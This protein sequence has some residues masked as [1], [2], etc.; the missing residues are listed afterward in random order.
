MKRR[1]NIQNGPLFSE[2]KTRPAPHLSEML[3]FSSDAGEDRSG[4]GG[5]IFF[6]AGYLDVATFQLGGS[7]IISEFKS[8][9][10]HNPLRDQITRRVH[11]SAIFRKIIT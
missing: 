3:P 4:G 7:I 10:V 8:C 9:I 1:R 2:R 5:K 11:H 6:K